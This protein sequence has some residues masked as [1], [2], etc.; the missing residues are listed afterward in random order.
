MP[1]QVGATPNCSRITPGRDCFSG[2]AALG[3]PGPEMA[4]AGRTRSGVKAISFDCQRCVSPLCDDLPEFRR[5]LFAVTSQPFIKCAL[6]PLG[7]LLSR[8]FVLRGLV[9]VLL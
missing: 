2:L 7:R 9:L 1:A 4:R 3:G 6:R 5:K 8:S